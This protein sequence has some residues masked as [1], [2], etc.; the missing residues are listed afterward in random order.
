MT[1]PTLC[2]VTPARTRLLLNASPTTPTG[3]AVHACKKKNTNGGH[4]RSWLVALKSFLAISD[5]STPV[6]RREG[7]LAG[8]ID[9]LIVLGR[10]CLK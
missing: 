8:N 2:T 6:H 10:Q 9:A 7:A 1:E 5:Y 4:V 3:H